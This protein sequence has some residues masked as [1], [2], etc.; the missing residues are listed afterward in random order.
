MRTPAVM[1][2]ADEQQRLEN[3]LTELASVVSPHRMGSQLRCHGVNC[4]MRKRAE[5]ARGSSMPLGICVRRA[6]SGDLRPTHRRRL[7]AHRVECA[8]GAD[9][10]G[11]GMECIEAPRAVRLLGIHPWMLI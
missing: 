10:A 8:A 2:H 9:R 3:E 6:S 11:R 4:P 7:A 5:R 1:G